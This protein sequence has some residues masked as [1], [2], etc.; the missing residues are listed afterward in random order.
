MAPRNK[1]LLALVVLF[2]VG[3]A[4]V[5][6]ALT[7]TDAERLEHFV[8][9]FVGNSPDERLTAALRLTDPAR[10]GVEVVD[11]GRRKTFRKGHEASLSRE[12]HRAL[13]AFTE[14]EL[15]VIQKAVELEGKEH[16][17]VAVRV[18]AGEGFLNVLFHLN[19]HD[20]DWLVRRVAISG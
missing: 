20:E 8:E 19:K 17:R 12:L 13:S 14:G 16:A 2:S 3:T 4:L 7:L 18:R 11:R 6:D 9:D 10:E 15:D 1:L 5:V